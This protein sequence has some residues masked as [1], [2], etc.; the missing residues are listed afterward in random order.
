MDRESSAWFLGL[1]LRHQGELLRYIL[2]LVGHLQDAQD[3]LQETA[4]ALWK[5][6][7]SYDRAQPF[8]PW[9]KR[10]ARN[11]VLMHHRRRKRFHFLSEE[12][13][14]AL[15]AAETASESDRRRREALDSCLAGLD[16]ADRELIRARYAA[17]DTNI[18]KLAA[19]SG[20]S[21]NVLYKA[22]A[23]VRR[24]LMDCVSGKLSAELR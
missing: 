16:A 22:L 13:L 20:E 12:L 6:L 18:Q 11:E 21:Q 10:F 1:L 14:D 4:T 3:V 7:D 9:A 19:S 8:L 15:E 17:P 23:R 24:R 2:P 5:K